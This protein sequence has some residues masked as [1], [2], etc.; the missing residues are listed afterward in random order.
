MHDIGVGDVQSILVL[1]GVMATTGGSQNISVELGVAF[2]QVS[3]E[4]FD[5]GTLVAAKA[6]AGAVDCVDNPHLITSAYLSK[7]CEI[8]VASIQSHTIHM[9]ISYGA[10][11][12]PLVLKIGFPSDA[13]V[14]VVTAAIVL[15]LI[16]GER[17]DGCPPYPGVIPVDSSSDSSYH[18]SHSGEH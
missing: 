6:V 2:R 9:V 17:D 3:R 10:V 12:T 18:G 5:S 16:F 8:I 11:A 4:E 15:A 7:H 14:G 13:G 1:G